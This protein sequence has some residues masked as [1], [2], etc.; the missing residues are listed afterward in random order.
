MGAQLKGQQR[1]ALKFEG[2]GPLRK[3][4]V[5][6]DASGAVCGTVGKHDVDLPP[7]DGREDVPSALGRAGFLTVTKDLGMKEPYQ[8]VVQLA[9][10][11]IG[12]DLALYLTESEQIPSAVG[13]GV[14]IG[15]AGVLVA[16]GF[17][18]QALPPQDEAVI[19]A[20][21]A[22]IGQLTSLSNLLKTDKTP[23]ALL[24]HLFAGIPYDILER[25]PLRFQCSCSRGKVERA[26]ISLGPQ[27]LASMGS[28]A[29]GTTV[30]CEFCKEV[31]HFNQEAL[32]ALAV[33]TSETTVQG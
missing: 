22:R 27:E 13:L 19:D 8:G 23:E 29:E 9:T 17:L 12:D 3:I 33:E 1:V 30:V 32:Q 25:L 15:P 24:E 18:V 10:S 31:Y 14:A 2:S 7:R 4:L 28:T 16:G 5:E 11:E 20:L 21:M 26:L 6:A